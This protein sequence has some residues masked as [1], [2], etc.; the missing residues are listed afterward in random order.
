MGQV[1]AAAPKDTKEERKER[2][3]AAKIVHE[4]RKHLARA[5]ALQKKTN[6]AKGD[7]ISLTQ[8]EADLK[9][10]LVI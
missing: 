8:E 4:K 1:P 5:K 6:A 2:E 9:R 7:I 3:A 10:K